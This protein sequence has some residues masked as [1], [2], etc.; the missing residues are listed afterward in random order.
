MEFKPARNASTQTAMFEPAQ[1][2]LMQV[3]TGSALA[4]G[5]AAAHFKL[6]AVSLQ[7]QP[8]AQAWPWAQV[9]S[10]KQVLM[11]SAHLSKEHSHCEGHALLEQSMPV[12]FK[13]AQLEL[14]QVATGS[15]LALG[16]AA[17]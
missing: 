14:M 7:A 1:L 8:M 12:S 15:A 4:L 9:S 3:A 2:E 5:V 11:A 6:Q 10:A 16:V 17:A 13:P